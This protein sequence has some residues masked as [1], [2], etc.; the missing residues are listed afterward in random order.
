MKRALGGSPVAP[1]TH[2]CGWTRGCAA[3]DGG[4]LLLALARHSSDD[5]QVIQAALSTAATTITDWP[6]RRVAERANRANQR[7]ANVEGPSSRHAAPRRDH[8]LSL[9]RGCD[10]AATPTLPLAR[11]HKITPAMLRSA[12][13]Q[14]WQQT[15]RQFYEVI[16]LYF[17]NLIYFDFWPKEIP[18]IK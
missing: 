15:Q 13:P 10:H 3:G 16:I 7:S 17:A 8:R 11:G 12:S 14:L 1:W 2:L 5:A 18:Q 4:V 6:A 9:H